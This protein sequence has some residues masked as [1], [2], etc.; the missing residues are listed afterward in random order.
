MNGTEEIKRQ[1][2][3]ANEAN[4]KL[5]DAYNTLK[6]SFEILGKEKTEVQLSEKVAIDRAIQVESQLTYLQQQF[7]NLK[8]NP[9]EETRDRIIDEYHQSEKLQ[10][11]CWSGSVPP[12]VSRLQQENGVIIPEGSSVHDFWVVHPT[13]Y[14]EYAIDDEGEEADDSFLESLEKDVNAKM[15]D[16]RGGQN[17]MLD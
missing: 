2:N 15:T 3:E 14:P 1:L 4:A 13:G 8:A 16:G 17:R 5:Q 11:L 7:E 6:T 10:S 12:V 9:D